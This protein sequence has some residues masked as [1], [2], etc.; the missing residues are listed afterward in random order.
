[1]GIF[2]YLLFYVN[3]LLL[4]LL[5]HGYNNININITISMFS[6]VYLKSLQKVKV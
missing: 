6:L 1:M 4:L 2:I 5:Y 3:E